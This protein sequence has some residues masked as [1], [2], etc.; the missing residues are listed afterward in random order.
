L[1]LAQEQPIVELG[2]EVKE[3]LFGFSPSLSGKAYWLNNKTLEFT[4]DSG[5]LQPG[6]LY[7]VTFALGK[8]CQVDKKFSKFDFSF[9]VE[10]RDFTIKTTSLD[11]TDPQSDK[12]A[13]GGEIRFSETPDLQNVSKMIAAERNGDSFTATVQA[14]DDPHIFRF[15]VADIDKKQEETILKI[16][17]SG[18]SVGVNK[19][20][21]AEVVI[22]EINTFKLLSAE[23]IETPEFGIR[24][25]FSSPVSESQDLRGMIS[26]N[27]VSNYVAQVQDNVVNLFFERRSV[28]SN[29]YMVNVTLDQGLK[30]TD[31][32]RLGKSV[33]ASLQME[34]L[35]PA[36][37]FL[38]S[39]TIMPN[40]QNLLLP[41]RAVSLYAV[42]LKIIRIYENNVLMFLQENNLSSKSSYSLRRYGRLIYK[43]TLRLDDPTKNIHDWNNYSID[44]NTVIKQEPGAIYRVE[45]T[46]GKNYSAYNCG[47]E[48]V[49]QMQVANQLETIGSGEMTEEDEAVW[50]IAES[51]YYENEI[52]WE[53]YEWDQQHNPCHASYYMRSERKAVTNVLAS[54][55]G[56]IVKGNTNNRLWV[57]V[58]DLL[59]TKPVKGADVTAYNFQ[60]QPVGSA[61]T[62]ENGF[63]VLDTKQQPFA[64]V[65]TADKQKTYLKLTDG[66]ENMLSRFDVGGKEIKKGLKGYIY[67]E[68]GVWRPGD[69]LHLSFILE[70]HEQRIPAGYPVSLEVY[71]PRGQFA[72]K[73]V[74]VNGLNSFYTFD[75]PTRADDPTGLW[76]AYV[77]VGGTSFHKP[78]RIEAIKPNRL[79]INVEVPGNR[80]SAGVSQTPVSIHAAWL[81]GAVARNLNTSM[82][83]SLSKTVSQFKGYEKYIFDNPAS[84]FSSSD[85]AMN[86]FE[87][88]LDEQGDVRFNMKVPEAKNAPGLLRAH[89][90]CNVYEQGGDVSIN[91]Q[92]IPFSPFH[93]YVG[94]NFN[95]KE[96][97]SYFET[98]VEN[99]FDIVT[100][101]ADGKPVNRSGLEYK[102]YRI[103]WS[104]W[105]EHNDE[106]FAS[107][108]QNSSII[109]VDKGDLRTVNGKAQIKFKIN[110]PEW[111]RYLVYVKDRD[112][113][114]A[115]GGVV[116]VDWPDWRGRSNKSDP[117]GAKML[118]FSTDKN[119]YET[120]ETVTVIIPAAAGGRALVA[121]ENGSDVFSREWVN[122]SAAGDTKYTFKVTENMAPNVYVHISLLQP[123]E[124]TANDLPIRMYGVMPV[125]VTNKASI[126]TPRITM[127][128]V[129]RPETEFSVKVKEANGKAMTYT[130]AVVDEGLLD[131]TNFKTPDPWNE[132]YAR[133]AL[134]I[135]TWDMYDDVIGAFAGKYGS[136]FSIGGDEGRI[137][138]AKANRFKPVVRFI[139][140]FALKKGEEKTHPLTLPPYIGSVRV[141]VVAGQNG[142]YGNAEKTAPVRTPLM[143]LP[144]LPRVV[145]VDEEI[146]LPVNV[147]VMEN[148][149][150]NVTVKVETTGKLKLVSAQ[151]KTLNFSAPGDEIVYFTLQSGSVTGV[152]KVT[153]TATGDGQTS[154]ETIEIDVRNPNPP[155]VSFD[156][157]LL[158]NG[159]T[160]EFT[161]RLD[162]G[163]GDN[164]VKLE[165]SRIPS[166]DISR[167]FD[168]LY[169]YPHY[170]SEQLTSRALPLLY[171]PLF[172]DMDA[173][174]SEMIKKNVRDAIINLYGRQLSNG[175]IVYWP[176][177]N[178]ENEWITSYAGSFLVLAKEK[179][180]DVNTAVINRWK[181]Y[182]RSA[183]QNWQPTTRNNGRYYYDQSDLTQSYRLYTLA[184]AGAPEIG[185]MNRLKE[186]K[187]IS[188]QARWR[189]AAAY[190]LAG[191]M[192]AANE[193]IFNAP[194][195]IDPY[196]SSN[197]SYGSSCRDEA[198]ILETFILMGKDK[199]AFVQAEKV[200]KSL[201]REMYFTT[202]STAYSLVAMGYLAGKLSEAPSFT[203]TLNGAKQSIVKQKK[204]V[205]QIDIPT[206]PASG[207][208]TVKDDGD[209]VLYVNLVSK[210]KPLRDSLPAVENNIRLDVNYTDL[211][212]TPV[213]VTRLKQ[214]ADFVAVIKVTNISGVQ[215]YTDL[216]LTQIIPSGWEIRNDRMIDP[217]EPDNRNNKASYTYQDL[218]DDR[219]LTYFDLNYNTSKT[220]K[221]RLM[222]SYAGRFVIPAIQCEAMYDT[223]VQARTRAG[224]VVVEK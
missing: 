198:M 35:A 1:E 170:C 138:S 97:S 75:V 20:M 26:L 16:V 101:D 78:L 7:N 79:K 112:G 179:G 111:G 68:R 134:G 55:L 22:P 83:I 86:V 77:K 62:D 159:E 19:T 196:S 204:A 67:G 212:G 58:T 219:V 180:Y 10:E 216:A 123:H 199:E 98:D 194:T 93:T 168:F 169:Y 6:T 69:T 120:G 141:M 60:L 151:A 84:N 96:P 39:G 207:T 2:S 12:V 140:P 177:D 99:V 24:L 158:E 153:V 113:G 185:A 174:E 189:L 187:N 109:P 130:L 193:L 221:I 73:Q 87:G 200:S 121:L 129:L 220:F 4:P 149:V 81:T 135:R 137:G 45:L 213:D 210:T 41:F 206:K 162:E 202:Q 65:A 186:L 74:S 161:Y 146:A 131:L 145:S 89:L 164:W 51:Y 32:D 127:A 139:G 43:K 57:A 40:S 128:D 154:K 59:D 91:N 30:N 61:R 192:N 191:K 27:E 197:S 17:A 8:V 126:L 95:Q 152:E 124:Q 92:S 63:V 214:G 3:K 94:I 173:N 175:G 133:E 102:I 117:S 15:T 223:N 71:N 205:Y 190:A 70:D 53:E 106:S 88:K 150:K 29:D 52:D 119:S 34:S 103:G 38:S 166:I 100:V 105:W 5:A 215:N 50:N 46:F 37:E 13:V 132:F 163:Y 209:G 28:K 142:A 47:G 143:V 72:S 49:G 224:W 203:W 218:R 82:E 36:V 104:W 184:L 25:T 90:S 157:K 76:S 208:V 160:G 155:I 66:Q 172:K 54:N 181:N 108:L 125:F 118:T 23:F 148:T 42:D 156:N 211:G 64:L 195:D 107:Y 136:L 188:V 21:R 31:N 80:I 18:K 182:Q 217:D 14:S 11:I 222:A 178:F 165:V 183:A 171:I 114:H 116:Y 144:S 176:G 167:R 56:V 201:M 85:Y 122:V 33:S 115:T 44:L 48:S 147:F 110:Y 9:R